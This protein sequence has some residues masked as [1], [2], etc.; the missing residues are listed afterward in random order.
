VIATLPSNSGRNIPTVALIAHLDTAFETSGRGVKPRIAA[1]AGGDVVLDPRRDIRIPLADY[2]EL[3]KFR[4]QELIVAD[5]STLLGGDDKAGIA[6]IVD[7]VEWLARHPE[8]ERGAVKVVFTPDEEIGHLAACLDIEKLGAD[9]AYTVDAGDLGEI[10]WETF[11]AATATVSMAGRAVH[12]G[13]AKGKMKNA[14]VMLIDFIDQLPAGERPEH[15]EGREGYFH[16]VDL[17]GAVDR[18]TAVLFIRDH[19]RGLF[20]KRKERLLEIAGRINAK[21]GE[22]SCTV[23]IEDV[24]YNLGDKL[25]DRMYIVE[26]ARE[27]VRR[28]GVEPYDLPFRGGTDGATLTWRG[29]PTPNIFK[30]SLN[31]HG[32]QEY[33]PVKSLEKCAEVLTNVVRIIAEQS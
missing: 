33:Q 7:A 31:C 29:L 17:A 16:V 3:A 15:T 30:G 19:D 14:N 25:K 27:A 5:G 9:F 1:Y 21:Y 20:E 26:Y 10:S 24:Y 28:A 2:P 12:P 11:N 4:G 23:E 6:A 18:A 32:V 13:E 22:G 8:V